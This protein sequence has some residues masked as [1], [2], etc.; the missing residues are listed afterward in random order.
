MFAG[1]FF[2]MCLPI[3]FGIYT[4]MLNYTKSGKHPPGPLRLPIIGAGYNSETNYTKYVFMVYGGKFPMVVLNAF[5]DIKE[6]AN[7]NACSDRGTGL[8]T[9]AEYVQNTQGLASADYTDTYNRNRKWHMT[10][11]RQL[12]M[13][14]S[15]M[16]HMVTKECE[17]LIQH[18]K[19]F[20]RA[21][22][23][24][25]RFMHSFAIKT[26]MVMLLKRHFEKNDPY[27]IGIVQH[28]GFLT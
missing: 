12:G 26:V 2:S 7:N 23:N 20:N 15:I 8:L 25:S 1:I 17:Q 14:T 13:R 28:T 27:F 18:I 11:M 19:S 6:A 22:F 4:Y 16:D 21:P 24:P 5:E 3:L 10:I 9:F